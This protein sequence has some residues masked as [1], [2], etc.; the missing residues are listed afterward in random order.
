MEKNVTAKILPNG[1]IMISGE[2]H[3]VYKDGK[4]ETKSN[5]AFCRCGKSKNKPFCDG[6]HAVTGF[7]DE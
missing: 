4:E 7:K 3:I 5:V 1:P 6:S 2:I